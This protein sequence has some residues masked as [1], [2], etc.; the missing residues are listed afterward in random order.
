LNKTQTNEN[1]QANE[2]ETNTKLKADKKVTFRTSVLA[3]PKPDRSPGSEIQGLSMGG[4][5]K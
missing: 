4:G 2:I 5:D 3:G 1:T